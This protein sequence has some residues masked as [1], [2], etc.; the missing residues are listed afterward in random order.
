MKRY[1]LNV[2]FYA[3]SDEPEDIDKGMYLLTTEKP[4]SQDEMDKIF[5]E[6]NSQLDSFNEI[7]D[8]P[9]SYDDGLNIDTLMEGVEYYTKGNIIQ[10]YSD[11][12]KI[13]DIDN[14]YMISQWQ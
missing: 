7:T 6:V 11:Y 9:F 4:I 13:H 12:G 1:L 2:T 3:G 10:L 14:Y 8:F 5:E